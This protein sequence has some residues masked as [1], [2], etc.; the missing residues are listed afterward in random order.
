MHSLEIYRKYGPLKR[1]AP[2]KAWVNNET[3]KYKQNT[4]INHKTCQLQE[5]KCGPL[6]NE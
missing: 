3:W 1:E 4:Y 5:R 6:D 2:Y